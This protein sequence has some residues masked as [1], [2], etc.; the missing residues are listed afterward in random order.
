MSASKR[1]PKPAQVLRKLREAQAVADAMAA[2]FI[3]PDDIYAQASEE[4]T[5]AQLEWMWFNNQ[6]R[7]YEDAADALEALL[8]EKGPSEITGTVIAPNTVFVDSAA[9]G[10][11]L[12]GSLKGLSVTEDFRTYREMKNNWL[13]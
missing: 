5:A 3:A 7:I 13:K 2:R 1:K 11:I 10:Q 6:S 12:G 9:A 4:M 8:D